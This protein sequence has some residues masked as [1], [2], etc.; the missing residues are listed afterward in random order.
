MKFLILNTD[1]P[2]FLSW[3]Y[4][5]QPGLGQATYAEQLR[6]RMKSLFGVADF[7]SGNLRR[8]G[9]EAWDIHANN[10][11]MQRAWARENGIQV[12]E[13]ENAPRRNFQRLTLEQAP[14]RCMTRVVQ[15]LLHFVRGQGL[16]VWFYDILAAQIEQLRPDVLLNQD[17]SLSSKF[18][19]AMKQHI[20]LLVGQHAATCLPESKD[21][22]CYDLVISSFRPTVEFF[23]Q[24]G[25]RSEVSRLAF[26]PNVLSCLPAEN[27]SHGC[28]FVGS[29]HSVHQSRTKLLETL[30]GR[31]PQMRIWGPGVSSLSPTSAIRSCYGGQAWGRE[32]YEIL[33][34]SKIVVNHHGDIAPYAN[35]LRL[36]EATGTGA[37]LLTDWKENLREMFEPGKEVATYRGPE[38]CIEAVSYYLEHEDARASIAHAGQQ[39]T[40]RDHSYTQR[41][42]EF[43]ELVHNHL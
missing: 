13:T 22:S 8:L 14:L 7:Y 29:F 24:K 23:R 43:V 2:E 32:M 18:L 40:L 10:E 6:A 33:Y 42:E 35:N 11:V 26:E 37:L 4:S 21:W 19:R 30:C 16:P 39:R 17:M 9:H 15:P 31:F 5:K 20:R 27:R 41:M 12:K 38:E 36:F 34:R 1:Y 3:L 25:I 28:V